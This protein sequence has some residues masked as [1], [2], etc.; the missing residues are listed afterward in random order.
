MKS[1]ELLI[2][3]LILAAAL[4]LVFKYWKTGRKS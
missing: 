3:L 2:Y 1:T 4:W